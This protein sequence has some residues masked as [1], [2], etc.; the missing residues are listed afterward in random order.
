MTRQGRRPPFDA[1]FDGACS[2]IAAPLEFT[3]ADSDAITQRRR[4][5]AAEASCA[6]TGIPLCYRFSDSE[7]RICFEN[8]RFF[9]LP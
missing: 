3:D 6:Q 5:V 7:T 9:F 8:Q 2:D 4:T 1:D